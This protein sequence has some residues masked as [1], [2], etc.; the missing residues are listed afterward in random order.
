MASI[1]QNII[2]SIN[3][4]KPSK[5]TRADESSWRTFVASELSNLASCSTHLKSEIT[6]LGL[7]LRKRLSDLEDR[8]SMV[9]VQAQGD[10]KIR[11][12]VHLGESTI[13]WSEPNNPLHWADLEA[14]TIPPDSAWQPEDG[15]EPQPI[16][17]V[18]YRIRGWAE[19]RIAELK[20]VLIQMDR[21]Y[22]EDIPRELRGWIATRIA[23]LDSEIGADTHLR[24][25][26]QVKMADKKRR[27]TLTRPVIETNN[28]TAAR[29]DELRR[30]FDWY[31]SH[32][33]SNSNIIGR[34]EQRRREI[35]ERK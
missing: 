6:E 16:A 1:T 28:T 3:M 35:E 18:P 32:G 7:D 9:H 8:L 5:D 27:Q 30:L 25:K 21:H 29:H 24:E 2:D 10:A 12:K 26:Q 15:T 14:G 19:E 23:A 11:A 13:Q 20:D 17:R 33:Y 31:C 34:I 22:E 4:A